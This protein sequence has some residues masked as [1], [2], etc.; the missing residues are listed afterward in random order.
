MQVLALSSPDTNSHRQ[1][2]PYRRALTGIYARLAATA[3][4]LDGIEP[5]RHEIGSAEPYA[6]PDALRA[7]LKVLANSLK[8]N[9][10]ARLVELS[11]PGGR[12]Y[13]RFA[14]L[15]RDYNAW[16]TAHCMAV[17]A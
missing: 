16:Y 2:E 11:V 7:D 14:G 5:V 12:D 10:S 6:T 9:G 3:R 1:D 4:F 15:L 13:P 8:L 17:L